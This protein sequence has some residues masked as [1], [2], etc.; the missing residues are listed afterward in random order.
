MTAGGLTEDE[1]R[2]WFLEA[3]EVP[4]VRSLA[5][6]VAMQAGVREIRS[7]REDYLQDSFRVRM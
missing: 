4:E 3:G 7:R 5:E 2:V 1:R 6:L